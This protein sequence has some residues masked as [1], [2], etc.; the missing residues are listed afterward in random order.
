ML[1]GR[2]FAPG[3]CLSPARQRKS[4]HP[5]HTTADADDEGGDHEQEED[6]DEP[7]AASY[8]GAGTEP[9]TEQ[10]RS[11]HEQAHVPD[12][13]TDRDEDAQRGEVGRPVGEPGLG[14]G[15]EEV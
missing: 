13:G 2:T 11:P 5:D 6:A 1:R 7:A 9:A 12:D 14:A 10:I 15:L 8:G 3:V 4:P